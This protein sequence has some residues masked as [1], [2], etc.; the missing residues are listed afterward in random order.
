MREGGSEPSAPPSERQHPM[1]GPG[2]GRATGRSKSPGPGGGPKN[3]RPISLSHCPRRACGKCH[4]ADTSP[5]CWWS[6]RATATSPSTIANSGTRSR[7]HAC[8]APAEPPQ[9]PP[10][11]SSAHGRRSP[12]TGPLQRSPDPE[13][14]R[15]HNGP[16]SQSLLNL[17][18]GSSGSYSRRSQPT[19]IELGRPVPIRRRRSR[20]CK[21]PRADSAQL[22]LSP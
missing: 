18:D 19:A 8:A 12:R 9:R 6:D 5:A 17:D 4:R 21:W 14:T 20:A 11:S 3:S 7:P 1:P 15:P 10:T 16:G 2:A 13:R 22:R